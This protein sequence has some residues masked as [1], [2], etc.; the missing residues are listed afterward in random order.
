MQNKT[1]LALDFDHTIIDKNSD[2]FVQR[3]APNGKVINNV[4]ANK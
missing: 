3:L 1:L 2:V 4:V